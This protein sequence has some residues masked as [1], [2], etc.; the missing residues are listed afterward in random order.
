MTTREAVR[1]ARTLT[2]HAL[3][4]FSRSPLSAF[5][6][7]IFPLAFL[8]I[9]SAI[10]GN[11]MT[12]AGVPVAQFL[13]APFAVFGVAQAT[14]VVLATDL[15]GLRERGILMRLRGTPVP[16]RTALAARVAAMAAVSGA[17]VAL[18]T[19]VGVGLYGVEIVWRK[20]PALVLTLALG[21]FCFAALG[22]ALVALTRTVLVVQTLAQGLL[23]PL[24]FIS[25]VFI[26]GADLPVWLDRIGMVLPLRHFA[27]AMAQ[28]F[29]PYGGYGFRP[30][31]LLVL[32][33][34]GLAGAVV[35]LRRFDWMPRGSAATA[36]ATAPA[37]K[38]PAGAAPRR[39]NTTRRSSAA[40]LGTQVRYALTSQW[41]DPLSVFFAVAFPVL[42]LALFPA[43]FGDGPVHG[44][45]TAQY[46]LPGMTA[47]AIAVAGYVNMPEDV[48]QA[49]GKGVL[50]RLLGT[51]LPLRWYV[52]GRVSAVLVVSV[53]AAV[54]LATVAVLFLDVGLDPAR[55][56]A[57]ALGVLLG[58]WCFAAL[59]LA[60]VALLRSANSLVA[61]TLGTLLPLSFVSD[62][63]PVGDA[64]LPGPLAAVGD[65]FPLKHLVAALLAATSPDGAGAGL[66]AGHLAVVAGWTVAGLL[67][68]RLRGLYRE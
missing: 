27:D 32:A 48:A 33:A 7:L 51:P 58:V 44:L 26:V 4:G 67:V 65:L 16:V 36:P 68:I 28:T 60:A 40:L 43:V 22:L 2:A 17:A 46:L 34:W 5:F 6:T 15:A 66:A 24:A 63:F 18:L 37:E 49:R 30:G 55:L 47:Y 59:G 9:V 31:D 38:A 12:D 52:A 54:L 35:A 1:P 23:I 50:K 14:F 62:V 19:G 25:G 57:L 3:R 13:V 56:P 10:V 29:D 20:V 8:I 42:L 21:I 64:P 45:T 41:R 53:A 61:V 39:I 11:E